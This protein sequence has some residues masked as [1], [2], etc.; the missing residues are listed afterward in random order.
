MA[1]YYF[2]L[3][4]AE[5]Y[6]ALAFSSVQTGKPIHLLEKDVW[7]VWVLRTL[8]TSALA[9]DL[10]FKGGTSLSKAYKLID[11]FSE[12]VDLTYD[13]RR[14]IPDLMP[15]GSSLPSSRS[16]SGKWTTA[17]RRALPTWINE[18]VLPVIS[19]GLAREG[20]EATVGLAE[21][22]MDTVLLS[23]PALASGTGYVAPI[24]R[25]EFGGR[26][27][28]EPHTEM[29]VRCDMEGILDGVSFPQA[30]PLVMNLS[31]TF[32]EKATA[33]H[34]YCAQGRIRG[35]RY[36]R[37]WHDLMSIAK[38]N[39]FD[40]VLNDKDVAS[41]VADHKSCFFIEK[42]VDGNIVDY[43]KAVSGGLRIVPE[44]P[45]KDALSTDYSAMIKDEVL[46]EGNVTFDELMSKCEAIQDR[47][48]QATSSTYAS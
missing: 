15:E 18:Q 24:V 5:Q 27:T 3:S 26:A 25:L 42:D 1:E 16:Q 10:T 20:L 14:L 7:V 35:E 47:L 30:S 40:A 23:Y 29:P 39:Q 46:V 34:V 2:D 6:E 37:H 43:R 36:A 11:R 12:D 45:A 31:R 28:G 4:T 17:V 33:A 48:N 9:T 38:S 8:F 22:G 19:D 13:I 32:W 21:D 44:G 41:M